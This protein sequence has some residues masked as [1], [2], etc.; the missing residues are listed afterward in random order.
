MKTQKKSARG[1]VD[2][3]G[4]PKRIMLVDDHPLV[5]QGLATL[6]RTTAD[7]EVSAEVGSA[8]EAQLA[9]ENGIPDLM[10]LDIS[11]PGVNGIDLLKDLHIRYPGLR[12]LVISMHEE[13]VYAERALRAGARGYIMKHEPGLKVLEAIRCVLGG[14]LY[15]SPAIASQMLKLFVSSKSGCDK[16]TDMERLSDRELQVYTQIGN[17]LATREIAEQF[18]LSCK[19]IQTYREH[20]KRKLGLRSATELVH[21]ATHWVEF[22]A[23][24]RNEERVRQDAGRSAG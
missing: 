10:L 15:V 18:A 14:E 7:Q 5:R 6:I 24:R 12:V 19:T 11:M 4:Q 9:L 1:A 16:R 2:A 13:S 20:I 8:A 17:G 22:E 3:A 21:H 23:K